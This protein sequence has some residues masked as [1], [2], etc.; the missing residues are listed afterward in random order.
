[1][2]HTCI[3]NT[4]NLESR[5]ETGEMGVEREPLDREEYKIEQLAAA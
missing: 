3:I 5:G 2:I 1:M 4:M